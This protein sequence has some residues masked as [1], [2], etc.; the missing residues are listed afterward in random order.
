MVSLG[1]IETDGG[2]YLRRAP[3]VQ[4]NLTHYLTAALLPNLCAHVATDLCK[5]FHLNDIDDGL[6]EMV[7]ALS[8]TFTSRF[9]EIVWAQG[10]AFQCIMVYPTLTPHSAHR[11]VGSHAHIM[12]PHSTFTRRWRRLWLVA[13]LHLRPSIDS[14][15]CPAAGQEECREEASC[16]LLR[17]SRSSVRCHGR[18]QALPVGG[19]TDGGIQPR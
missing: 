13:G 9:G 16:L 15:R 11:F 14:G 1:S 2:F 8:P 19:G 5:P 10:K 7:T 12:S 4:H 17:V 18:L 3:F 6:N